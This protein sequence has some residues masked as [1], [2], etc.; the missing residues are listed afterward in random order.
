[1]TVDRARIKHAARFAL[2]RQRPSVFLVTL[3]YMLI[4]YVIDLLVNRIT[5]MDEA[6]T[7]FWE[8]FARGGVP[9]LMMPEPSPFGG[10]LTFALEIMAL[11]LSVGFMLYCLNTSRH[12]KAGFGTLFDGFGAF[13]RIIGMYLLQYVF[14]L[15]WSFLLIIPGI[16]AAYRYRMAFYILLDHPELSVRQCLRASK[17]LMR[18]RKLELFVLD[19][20]FLG[21][22]LL[23]IVPF[24]GIWV[25]PYME[26]TYANYYNTVSGA[27]YGEHYGEPPAPENRQPWE[28]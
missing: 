9:Q 17:E 22:A 7:R 3:V 2:M 6:V 1:M 10:F 21:W 26:T 16:I 8:D 11:V 23:T 12:R 19:L 13:F 4:L 5:G 27:G 24:V 28:Y 15:L 25:N 18:G 14:I 20:S